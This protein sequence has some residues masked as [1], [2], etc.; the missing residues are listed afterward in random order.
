MKTHL[1][2]Q[3]K[4]N[5]HRKMD[6]IQTTLGFTPSPEGSSNDGSLVSVSFCAEDIKEFLA[7]MLIIDELPFKFVDNEGF[8][9]FMLKACP[10]F[11][12]IPSRITVAKEC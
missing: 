3:C 7:E 1:E 10:K 5:P 2:T 11:S 4:K 9:K 6:K 8:R 12:K